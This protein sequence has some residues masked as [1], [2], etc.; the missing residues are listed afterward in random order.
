MITEDSVIDQITVTFDGD[1]LVRRADRVLRDGEVI[2][3]TYH[4]HVVVAGEPISP[5]EHPDV[6]KVRRALALDGRAG[7]IA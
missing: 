6:V 5:A 3:A 4:R 2:A 1:V 7:R